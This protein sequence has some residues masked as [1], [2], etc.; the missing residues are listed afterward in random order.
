[1]GRQK[2]GGC[3]SKVRGKVGSTIYQVKKDG[4]GFS[5]Y[6]YKAA[7]TRENPNTEAQARARMIMGHV[8]RMF[9]ALP[10]I[11]KDAFADV[12]RGTLSFQLFSKLNYPL[13]KDDVDNHWDD[14]GDF[15]WQFKYK[16]VPPAGT[17]ILSRG[18]LPAVT[19]D[20]YRCTVGY[21]NEFEWTWNFP[22]ERLTLGMWLARLGM[23]IEDKLYVMFYR[24]ERDIETPYIQVLRLSVNPQY[25]DSTPFAYMGDNDVLLGGEDWQV[26]VLSGWQNDWVSLE[27]YHQETQEE[28]YVACA[29]MMIV[30]PTD[31]GTLFSSAR[32]QWATKNSLY[33]RGRRTPAEVFTSWK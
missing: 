18:T 2:F 24:K 26:I 1:M 28:Y 4:I 3:R 17:W 20:D 10:D 27:I 31:R 14:G 9:H 30:H 5:Q 15:D 12:D 23:D 19:W 32:F 29:A 21:N 25:N 6:A 7:E 11:I 16:V 33:Y 8:Q 13:L 22:G